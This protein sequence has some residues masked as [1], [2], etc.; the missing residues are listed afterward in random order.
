MFRVCLLMLSGWAG[1]RSDAAPACV[2]P[3]ADLLAWVSADGE[4][5]EWSGRL[6]G[7]VTVDAPRV[8]GLVGQAFSIRGICCDGWLLEGIRPTAVS[9]LTVEAWIQGEGPGQFLGIIASGGD[10]LFHFYVSP[11]GRLHFSR[12]WGSD[13]M[14]DPVL[15]DADWHHVAVTR[16][17]GEVRFYLDGAEVGTRSQFAPTAVM[18]HLSVGFYHPGGGAQFLGRLDEVGVYGRALEASEI[19][20]IHRAGSTGKCLVDAAVAF[21][22]I[23]DRVPAGATVPMTLSVTNLGSRPLG[24]VNVILPI[25][26]G[27]AWRDLEV[28]QGTIETLGSEIQWRVGDLGSGQR[29]SLRGELRTPSERGF[30]SYEARLRAAEAELNERNN[31]AGGTLELLGPCVA[32]PE[33]IAAWWGGENSSYERMTASLATWLPW[34][35]QGEDHLFY[36]K[37]RVGEG[38]WHGGGYNALY[39]TNQYGVPTDRHTIEG[40]VRRERVDRLNVVLQPLA[41]VFSF[42]GG[43]SLMLDTEGMVQARFGETEFVVMG[44]TAIRDTLWHH[45]ALTR[46]GSRVRLYVDGRMAGTGELPLPGNVP[47]FVAIG[48]PGAFEGSIDEISLYRRA[49]EPSE[50]AAIH[51]AGGAGKCFEDVSLTFR[52]PRLHGRT[53]DVFQVT[54]LVT[55]LGPAVA[56]ETRVRAP[57]PDGMEVVGVT[58]STGAGGVEAGEARANLGDLPPGAVAWVSLEGRVARRTTVAIEATVSHGGG[59]LTSVNDRSTATVILHERCAP[60]PDGLLGWWPA[61]GTPADAL[62]RIHGVAESVNYVEGVRG[63]AFDPAFGG[64][65]RLGNPA[66]LHVQDLTLEAWVRSTVAPHSPGLFGSGHSVFFGGG[67][68]SYT[69]GVDPLGSMRFG[70]AGETLAGSPAI[71][72]DDG[73]HHVAVTR[74]GGMVT[75]FWD[76]EVVGTAELEAVFTFDH[77][78]ALA[79]PTGLT[80][81]ESTPNAQVDELAIYGRALGPEEIRRLAD[82]FESG[83][84]R[85]DLDLIEVPGLRAVAVNE[86]AT[87]QAQVRNWG[88]APADGVT[89]RGVVP[90]QATIVEVTSSRG[91]STVT[92]GSFEVG[93]GNLP[94]EGSAT[95]TVRIRPE[96]A[97]RVSVPFE[98]SRTGADLALANNAIE[99]G[100]ESVPLTVSVPASLSIGELAG[101]NGPPLMARLSVASQRPVTVRYALESGTARAGQDFVAVSGVLEFAPGQV[102]LPIVIPVLRDGIDEEDETVL[103]RLRDPVGAAIVGDSAVVTIVDDDVFPILMIGDVT[104]REG[105]DS[106]TVARLEVWVAGRS[107]RPIAATYRTRDRSAVAG[108]DY[109]D[110]S[111]RV[112]FTPGQGRQA[113]EVR[114]LGNSEPQG[115]RSLAVGLSDLVNAGPGDLTGVVTVVDDDLP[116][117]VPAAYEWSTVVSPK[118]P[119]EAVEAS[120][121]AVDGSGQPVP[122]FQGTA[123]LEAAPKGMPSPV[124]FSRI[125]VGSLDRV[126]LR[127]V[128]GAAVD[129][130]GWQVVLYD[131]ESWPSPAVTFVFPEGSKADPGAW[132]TVREGGV[133]PGRQPDFNLGRPLAWAEGM[134]PYLGRV[135]DETAVLLLD[136]EGGARDFVAVNGANPRQIVEPLP[137]PEWL[138][139]EAPLALPPQPRAW[140]RVGD[141]GQRGRAGWAAGVWLPGQPD[142]RLMVPGA[143]PERLPVNPSTVTLADGRWTGSLALDGW[144]PEVVLVA[145]DAMGR[146]GISQPFSMVSTGGLSVDFASDGVRI[147]AGTRFTHRLRVSQ[148]GDQPATGVRLRLEPDSRVLPG[149]LIRVTASSGTPVL[150]TNGGVLAIEVDLGTM[151]SGARAELEAEFETPAP[152]PGRLSET[153]TARALVGRADPVL[154]WSDDEAL[155]TREFAQ[156]TVEADGSTLAGWWDGGPT[157]LNQAGPGRAVAL[158]GAIPGPGRVGSG[159][160]LDGVDDGWLVSDSMDWPIL[161]EIGFSLDLWFRAPANDQAYRRV[162]VSKRDD[163]GTGIECLLIDGRLAM[164]LQPVGAQ[165]QPDDGPY[166]FQAT[167]TDDLR[168]GLWHHAAWVSWVR[169]LGGAEVVM[170]VDGKT[171]GNG[172]AGDAMELASGAAIH[173]GFAPGRETERWRGDLDEVV[174]HRRA[175]SLAEVIRIAGAGGNGRRLL[176]ADRDGDGLPDDWERQHGLNPELAGDAILDLDG[177]GMA[178]RDEYIA[179]TDPGSA[180]SRLSVEALRTSEGRVR[181]EFGVVSGRRYR[182]EQR[183]SWSGESWKFVTEWVAEREGRGAFDVPVGGH[184][185]LRIS[186]VRE[187]AGP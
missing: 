68:G 89:V 139:P 173:L 1:S 61:E 187:P 38:F 102:E 59:D 34:S 152:A 71:A 121:A 124:I 67:P 177:D 46:N 163:R 72:W 123:R 120:V 2:E 101:T 166:T 168:D 93:L 107:E 18:S 54:L 105:S 109:L 55:N 43:D 79:G 116:A 134:H 5:G 95:V 183:E 146:Q 108:R 112:S 137:I 130:T 41:G 145:K 172:T 103:V 133:A 115:P 142:S 33:G 40:W 114:I 117:G 179:G 161:N 164:V 62:G 122:D 84:C 144:A 32:V 99:V 141:P 135:T 98:V 143:L 158:G 24:G 22:S 30:L 82:R 65:I 16:H 149:H 151:A 35:P 132:L 184:G 90:G 74:A 73:W 27:S 174:F 155:E 49:L 186:V 3:P 97:G 181:L 175:L 4:S 125:D 160:R 25:P 75:F 106:N 167:A 21:G 29:A 26:G 140:V 136:R 48:A 47:A 14:T 119:G 45:L 104:V 147:T 36:R 92:G 7:E 64:A 153:W 159:Y 85:D 66:M 78:F 31:S 91:A 53:G 148:D 113:V 110:A 44:D 19:E 17:G 83:K 51:A 157:G 9:N 63:F 94:A 165:A 13:V 129:L 58:V 15:A 154:T 60:P 39:T 8:P 20:A 100:V 96:T 86:E 81:G 171:V 150:Q 42:L 88:F 127:N 6:G 77:G 37:G 80:P 111:G 57:I 170:K 10:G 169:P 50:I 12:I 128:S 162:M 178:N 180:S 11:E 52:E 126:E 118:E 69:W 87:I 28:T 176:A 185:F 182:L 23:P 76:G 138:W 70:R 131:G 56:P 156:P